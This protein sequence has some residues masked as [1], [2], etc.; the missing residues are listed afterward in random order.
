MTKHELATALR[1][2]N[3]NGFHCLHGYEGLGNETINLIK[4]GTQTL[5]D[6][7]IIL[8]YVTCS[9]C[10]EHQIE[11]GSQLDTIIEQSSSV[12]HFV[13][14]VRDNGNDAHSRLPFCDKVHW[15]EGE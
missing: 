15:P 12:D 1:K 6:L 2:N 11:I 9:A 7:E 3:E 14:L 4:I 8:S 5:G 13:S 10:D